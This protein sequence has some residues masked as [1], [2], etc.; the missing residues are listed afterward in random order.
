MR[1]P[2]C[3]LLLSAIIIAIGLQSCKRTP[4][5]YLPPHVV[6]FWIKD[7]G[8]RLPDT[9]L[10]NTKFYFFD[11]S[12]TKQYV[13]DLVR[14]TNEGTMQ[15]YTLGILGTRNICLVSG[16][17]NIKTFYIEY[18]GSTDIDTLYV[19]CRHLNTAEAEKDPCRCYFPHPREV[20]F[21]SSPAPIDTAT[22]DGNPIYL[23]SK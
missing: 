5:I 23:L 10:N 22:P 3:C 14:A 15:A 19:D 2:H 13:N 4:E 1:K 12:N 18:P 7:M 20:R 11:K 6:F 21:N 16:D 9:V 17:S 8:N